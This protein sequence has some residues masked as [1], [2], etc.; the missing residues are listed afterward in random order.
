MF[1]N[2]SI[3]LA[4]SRSKRSERKHRISNATTFG[5]RLSTGRTHGINM[6]EEQAED[7]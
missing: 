7:R 6:S 3:V 2:P 5:E 1:V 4:I